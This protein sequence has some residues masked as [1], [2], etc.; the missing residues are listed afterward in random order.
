MLTTQGQRLYMMSGFIVMLLGIQE[1]AYN[2]L[3]NFQ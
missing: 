3:I 2:V 1:E